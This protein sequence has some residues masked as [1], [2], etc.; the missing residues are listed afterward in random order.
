MKTIFES[1]QKE[2]FAP[3]I[4]KSLTVQEA[5][6]FIEDLEEWLDFNDPITEEEQY[7][8]K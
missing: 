7:E 4:I 6:D 5:R 3:G 1:T 2:V 8:D